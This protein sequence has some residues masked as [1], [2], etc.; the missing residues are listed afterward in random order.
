M[1]ER[2]VSVSIRE[3]RTGTE[4]GGHGLILL[5]IDDFAAYEQLFGEETATALIYD[6]ECRVWSSLPEGSG[7]WQAGRGQ[8]AVSLPDCAPGDLGRI[9]RAAQRAIAQKPLVCP[10]GDIHVTASAGCAIATPAEL[11]R[12]GPTAQRALAAARRAGNSRCHVLSATGEDAGVVVAA[13]ESCL[14]SGRL[15]VSFQPVCRLDGGAAA[16]SECL[17]RMPNDGAEP[18]PA[19]RFLPGLVAL[20]HGPALDR[21]MLERALVLLTKHRRLRLS[22]NICAPT[23]HDDGW[24]AAL[25]ARAAA[26]LALADRLTVEIGVQALVAERLAAGRF[27]ERVRQTSASIAID[28]FGTVELGLRALGS[29]GADMVKIPINDPA[30]R[31]GAEALAL[32]AQRLDLAVIATGVETPEDVA[33]IERIGVDLAQGYAFGAPEQSPDFSATE[34]DG[35]RLANALELSAF[36]ARASRAAPA[37]R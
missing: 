14:A 9:A 33:M 13:A 11:T 18:V 23:L 31:E 17:V 12:L 21:M 16:F 30:A 34:P 22:V 7:S 8:F 36:R 29:I 20:G 15:T 32:V 26:D 2:P 27:L 28:G 10:A 6:A 4:A 25:E 35:Q 37:S 1:I 3:G 24:M 19:A 5:E